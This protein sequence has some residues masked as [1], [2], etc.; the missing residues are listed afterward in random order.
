[1]ALSRTVASSV[2]TTSMS[3]CRSLIFWLGTLPACV[4]T[5]TAAA[6]QRALVWHSGLPSLQPAAFRKRQHQSMPTKQASNQPHHTTPTPYQPNPPPPNPQTPSPR[7]PTHLHD[8]AQLAEGAA[9][10]GALP[11]AAARRVAAVLGQV[12]H[13]GHNVLQ[14]LHRHAAC[15]ETAEQEGVEKEALLLV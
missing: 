8:V 11:P 10:R 3:P 4:W 9:L 15:G 1:M 7:G 13:A 14:P 2:S 5:G 12:L 6:A